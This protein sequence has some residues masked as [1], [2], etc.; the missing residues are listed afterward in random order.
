MDLH[1][2]ADERYLR[3]APSCA[4]TLAQ[5]AGTITISLDEAR[6]GPPL[7]PPP[8]AARFGAMQATIAPTRQS[9]SVSVRTGERAQANRYGRCARAGRPLREPPSGPPHVFVAAMRGAKSCSFRLA[10]ACVVCPCVS[11][12]LRRAAILR[13]A[14]AATAFLPRFRAKLAPRANLPKG[15]R[16]A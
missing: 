13:A 15:L 6:R 9:V 7:D 16:L 12:D 5:H 14:S 10:A 11:S 8:R 1:P 3:A 2:F 4:M